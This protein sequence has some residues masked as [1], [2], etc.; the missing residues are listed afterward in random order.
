M[1]VL[2]YQIEMAGRVCVREGSGGWKDVKNY[3]ATVSIEAL[4]NIFAETYGTKF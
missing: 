4:D 1:L 3:M 2:M